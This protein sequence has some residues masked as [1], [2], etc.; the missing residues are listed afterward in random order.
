MVLGPTHRIYV[1]S[2][3]FLLDEASQ[4]RFNLN[5]G[6]FTVNDKN[7]RGAVSTPKH[8]GRGC[9]TMLSGIVGLIIVLLVVGYFY[10]PWAEAADAKAYPPPGQLVDIGGYRLHINCIGTGSP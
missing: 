1:L 2:S 6:G 3:P 4:E 9:L 10:E 5:H 8:R 7:Q